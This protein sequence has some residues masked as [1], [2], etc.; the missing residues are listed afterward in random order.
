[1]KALAAS[2]EEKMEHLGELKVV[3]G[4]RESSEELEGLALKANFIMDFGGCPL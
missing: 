2:I 3:R 4:P 1:M